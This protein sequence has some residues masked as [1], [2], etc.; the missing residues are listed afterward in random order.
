MP[1]GGVADHVDLLTNLS[2]MIA[3]SDVLRLVKANSAK[4]VNE[5]H[6][7][8]RKFAWQTGYTAFSVGE[9]Q[10]PAVKPYID[11]QQ[12]RTFEG[13]FLAMLKRHNTQYDP[14]F[15]LCRK[16]SN[17]QFTP[18]RFSCEAATFS[19]KPAACCSHGP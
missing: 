9:S 14:K 12:T 7:S 3:I 10:S 19:R 8:A 11:N 13:E 5:H 1:A 2:P 16:L 17:E 6:P 4:W 18:Q 15:V